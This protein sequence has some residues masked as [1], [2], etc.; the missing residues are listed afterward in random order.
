MPS[1]AVDSDFV[2]AHG[3]RV[4][5]GREADDEERTRLWPGL[6]AHPTDY[7]K[8]AGAVDRAIPVVILEPSDEVVDA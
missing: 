1:Q 4:V 8:C 3:T 2:V 5:R 7:D 6:V